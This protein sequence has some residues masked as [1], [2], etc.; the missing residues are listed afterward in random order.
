MSAPPGTRLATDWL[1][2]VRAALDAAPTPVSFFFRDDDAGWDDDSLF[3]ML[4]SFE[5][6]GTPIDLAAIPMAVTEQLGEE[7]QQRAARGAIGVHQHGFTH[8]NNETVGRKCE[9]GSSR[10]RDLQRADISL[11]WGRL[12]DVLGDVVQPIFTPPWN[13]CTIETAQSLVDLGFSV[14]SRDITATPFGC[15]ALRELP[16]TIDWF[17]KESGVSIGRGEIARRIAAEVRGGGSVGV[18]L[19]HAVTTADDLAA[20]AHL[21]ALLAEHPSARRATLQQLANES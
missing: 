7:L 20:T 3:R 19:H 13:R 6:T 21:V 12:Q 16:V 17:K 4:D 2:P 5:E 18:M 11:G 15:A 8:V 9:F 10:P 14:L 1:Q